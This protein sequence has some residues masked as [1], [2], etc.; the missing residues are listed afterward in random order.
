MKSS[1]AAK[2]TLIKVPAATD[3]DN[4]GS[5]STSFHVADP[6][7]YVAAPADAPTVAVVDTWSLIEYPNLPAP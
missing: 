7:A 6:V 3:A 4:A 1:S 2:V 5:N